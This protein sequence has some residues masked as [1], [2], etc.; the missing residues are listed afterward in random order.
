MQCDVGTNGGMRGVVG[1]TPD[2]SHETLD[3]SEAPSAPR[4]LSGFS[5]T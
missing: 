4:K 3:G 2:A 5:Q 1:G